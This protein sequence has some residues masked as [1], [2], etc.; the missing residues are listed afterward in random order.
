MR[1]GPSGG[2]VLQRLKV[3]PVTIGA[4]DRSIRVDLGALPAPT[5]IYDADTWWLERE[6]GFVVLYFGQFKGRD[7]EALR[8]RLKIKYPNEALVHHLWQHSRKFHEDLRTVIDRWP[9][10]PLR[11]GPTDISNWPVEKEHS[12]W[13][14]FDSLSR[15]SGQATIDFYHLPPPSVVRFVKGNNTSDLTFNPVVRVLLG[16]Y[17]LFELLERVE[18]VVEDVRA[19]LPEDQRTS[20]VESKEQ[21]S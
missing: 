8:T 18:S 4:A 13:V 10:D 16:L 21:E 11:I 17:Q 9:S 12:D 2:Q 20:P 15:T 1:F 5:N 3:D 7:R 19:M 14:N 6:A